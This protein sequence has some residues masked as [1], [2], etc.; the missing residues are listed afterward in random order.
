MHVESVAWIT[1]RK[2]VLYAFFFLGGLNTYILYRKGGSILY[3]CSTYILFLLSLLSKSAAVC[4]PLVI[5]LTDYYLSNK[6]KFKHVLENLPL[7][8]ISIIFGIIALKSQQ[9]SGAV[10]DLTPTYSIFER[11]FIVCYSASSY[12]IKMFVPIGLC[13][14]HYFPIKVGGAM[15]WEFYGAVVFIIAIASTPFLIKDKKYKKDMIF[16]LLFFGVTIVMVLQI[17]PIGFSITSERY[18]YIPYIGLMFPLIRFFDNEI[19]IRKKTSPGLKTTGQIIMAAIIV[20]FSIGTY[21][22]CKVWEN[23]IALFT[24]VI[25]KNPNMFH[26]YWIR[27]SAYSNKKD[28]KSAISDFDNALQHNPPNAAEILNNLGNAEYNVN[29]PEYKNAL[30]HLDNAIKINPKLAE[31]Y[32]NRGNVKDNMNDQ[33]G[34]LEDLNKALQLKP[35][36]ITALNNRGVVYGKQGRIDE[37]I[38]DFNKAIEINPYD[39]AAYLNRGNAKGVVKDYAGSI[40]DLSIAIQYNPKEGSAY[41]N[42]AI[43]E[44]SLK[45][46]DAAC[47]DW[48]QALSLGDKVA[49]QML[50]KYCK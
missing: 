32:S 22:R 30:I 24:D 50:N 19:E 13:A 33:K 36:M 35:D 40:Q 44:I 17:I 4:F 8:I 38:K 45:N 28:Y 31:A 25:D 10:A 29:P 37:A 11:L 7:F 21:N 27:G 16:G 3:L 43:S 34:A 12:I 41:F 42:R 23:G 2:D 49:E 47:K 15:P 20:I 9:K 26:G 39:P 48:Q 5:I 1:E 46:N 14:M 6:L 18:T